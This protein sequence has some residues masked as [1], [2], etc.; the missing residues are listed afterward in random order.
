MRN[1]SL[2]ISSIFHPAFVPLLGFLLLYS[3]SGYALYIPENQFW[4]SVLI[5]IQFSILIPIG[6][7]YFLFWRKKI[8]SIELS[9]RKERKVP[10][11]INLICYSIILLVFSFLSFPPIIMNFL[12]AVIFSAAVSFIVSLTYKISLHMIAWGT[13]A[14]ALLA[15]SLRI[16]LEL[17]FFLSVIFLLSSLIASARLWLNE[18]SVSQIVLGWSMGFVFSFLI[19]NFL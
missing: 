13:L 14:G 19:M 4:F 2:I 11:V 7:V 1:L 18:H 5:I 15:Y 9:V 10:L 3:F 8:S 16:G 6:A 12:V 17:H